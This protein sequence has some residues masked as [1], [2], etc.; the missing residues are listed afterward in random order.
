MGHNQS[1]Q[2]HTGSRP[3]HHGLSCIFTRRGLTA[4]NADDHARCTIMNIAC[5][6]AESFSSSQHSFEADEKK[7]GEIKGA[8]CDGVVCHAADQLR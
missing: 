8:C 7:A 2:A 4:A 5:S 1:Q 3:H 6:E